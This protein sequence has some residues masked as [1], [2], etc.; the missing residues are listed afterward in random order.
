LDLSGLPKA[1]LAEA[2][3]ITDDQVI[4]YTRLTGIK[5]SR[6]PQTAAVQ[7]LENRVAKLLKR[8]ADTVIVQN[9]S[10]LKGENTYFTE[11]I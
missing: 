1:R 10:K 11:T 2:L 5:S 3:G 4:R 8:T 7:Q 9:N 6:A